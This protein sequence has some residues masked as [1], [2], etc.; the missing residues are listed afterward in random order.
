MQ[1]RTVRVMIFRHI[2][3]WRWWSHVERGPGLS[4]DWQYLRSAPDGCTG[5]ATAAIE[6]STGRGVA[7]VVSGHYTNPV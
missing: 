5:L 6:K 2:S 7:P 1:G 3:Q 4:W